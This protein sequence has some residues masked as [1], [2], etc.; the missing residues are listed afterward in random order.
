MAD[1]TVPQLLEA[2]DKVAATQFLDVI[3]EHGEA[4][5]ARTLKEQPAKYPRFAS[6]Q[7]SGSKLLAAVLLKTIS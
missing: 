5:L 1:V 2:C 4:A 7:T 3:F 6:I